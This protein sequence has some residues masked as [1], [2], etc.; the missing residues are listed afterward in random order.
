VRQRHQ[1]RKLTDR[2]KRGA[3][4]IWRAIRNCVNSGIVVQPRRLV[5]RRNQSFKMEFPAGRIATLTQTFAR[6][7]PPLDN[8]GSIKA[9]AKSKPQEPIQALPRLDEQFRGPA[10][11]RTFRADA[12]AASKP[13]SARHLGGR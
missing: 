5:P 4:V 10:T 7:V 1:K 2:L 11:A 13:A 9:M 12:I 6:I 3:R 8:R